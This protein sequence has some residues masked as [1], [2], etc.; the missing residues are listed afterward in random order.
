MYISSQA[1]QA[2]HQE[3]VNDGL[4]RAERRRLL[5][6][7]KEREGKERRPFRLLRILGHVLP[8]LPAQ[9]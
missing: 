7:V 9:S 5:A 6:T 8:G 4:R 1:L 2:M 3:I